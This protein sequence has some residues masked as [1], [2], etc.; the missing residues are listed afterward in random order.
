VPADTA[1]ITEVPGYYGTVYLKWYVSDFPV[2]TCMK[3]PHQNGNVASVLSL[4]GHVEAVTS[5]QAA[6]WPMGQWAVW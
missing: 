2:I 3:F 1:L 5:G 4:D 6:G